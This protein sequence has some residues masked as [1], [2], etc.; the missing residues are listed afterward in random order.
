MVTTNITELL[1]QRCNELDIL[2]N[3]KQLCKQNPEYGIDPKFVRNRHEAI[4]AIDIALVKSAK[5]LIDQLTQ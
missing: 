4:T 1:A 2:S 5:Q 3:Y